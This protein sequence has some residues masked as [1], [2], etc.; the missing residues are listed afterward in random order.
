M[1]KKTD[2]KEKPLRSMRGAPKYFAG[3]FR[4]GRRGNVSLLPLQI[5]RNFQ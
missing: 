4:A 2:G 5:G 3:V 1:K